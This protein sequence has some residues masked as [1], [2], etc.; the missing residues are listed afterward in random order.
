MRLFTCPN[1][2]QTVYFDNSACGRCGTAI[3]YDPAA[4]R[5]VAISDAA[6]YCANAE[7]GACNWI[8]PQGGLC[9]ACRHNETVP[10][11]S[12]ARNLSDWQTL[13]RAKKR[14]FYSLIRL[15]LPLITRDEDAERGLAFNFLADTGDEKVMTGHNKGVITIA[16]AEADDA[17]REKRR[18]EMGEPYRTLLGHFRHETAHYY[19]DLLVSGTDWLERCRAV[20]GNDAADYNEALTIHYANGAP[21][22]WPQRFVSS[23]AS[24]HPWEDFAETWA[25]Y[26]HIVDTLETAR[27]LGVSTEPMRDQSG[28]LS[29]DVDFD[30]YRTTDTQHLTEAWVGVSVMLNELNRSMGLPDAY[31]FVLSGP[32]VEKIDF[33]ARLV[34]ERRT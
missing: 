4:N 21:S 14:L 29:T 18:T 33:I 8:A 28:E 27:S 13:E 17:E 15:K 2:R 12:D 11:I 34:Q 7:H 25:H 3:G 26:L 19:W 23:Y 9:T 32:I 20:F 16:L 24:A 22:D 30:P 6:P 1:C 31:P 5:T 10:D